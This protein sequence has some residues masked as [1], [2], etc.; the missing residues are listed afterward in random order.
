M[1][2]T[3]KRSVFSVWCS[4]FQHCTNQ[5]KCFC[6]IGWRGPDCSI[7]MEMTPPPPLPTPPPDI[8]TTNL[9]DHMKKKE[10]PYGMYSHSLE[11]NPS[12]Y[13]NWN[14]QISKRFFTQE[15]VHRA[16]SFFPFLFS[17]LFFEDVARISNYK[18]NA[19]KV[20]DNHTK[21][22]KQRETERKRTEFPSFCF[23]FPVPVFTGA[24]DTGNLST[25]TMVFILVG[26]VKGVFICFAVVAVCYR[27]YLYHNYKNGPSLQLLWFIYLLIIPWSCCNADYYMKS[28]CVLYISFRWTCLY[29]FLLFSKSHYCILIIILKEMFNIIMLCCVYCTYYYIYFI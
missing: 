15:Y 12:P 3:R 25:L 22:K 18:F 23:L 24:H 4:F 7:Q 5:G 6:D 11:P 26:V 2:C 1:R 20:R 19:K 21:E 28:I 16:P 27:Y 9:Q 29:I 13:K 10:T 8:S 17:Y 14:F